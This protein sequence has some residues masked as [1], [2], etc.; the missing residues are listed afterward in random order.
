MIK[1]LVFCSFALPLTLGMRST[2]R[3][4]E[5]FAP[6]RHYVEVSS[7]VAVSLHRLAAVADD[8]GLGNEPEFCLC[9]HQRPAAS[10]GLR[11]LGRLGFD[12]G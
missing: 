7:W 10:Q 9:D 1:T 12:L 4:Q 11:W 6:G 5:E 3:A 8:R 2:S